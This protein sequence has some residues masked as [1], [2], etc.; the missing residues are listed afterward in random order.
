MNRISNVP[1][2]LYTI[3]AAYIGLISLEARVQVKENQVTFLDF[4]LAR[5]LVIIFNHVE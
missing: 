2:G 1:P 3:K 5:D 4:D